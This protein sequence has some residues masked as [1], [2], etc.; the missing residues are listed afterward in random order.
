MGGAWVENP[1]YAL[2]GGSWI[3][4]PLSVPSVSSVV[5]N[6]VGQAPPYLSDL[7]MKTVGGGQESVD[8]AWV[9][10]PPYVLPFACSACFA[11]KQRLSVVRSR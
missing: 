7:Q 4:A 10:N 3:G 1:P 11:L 2:G 8:D 5:K 9:E 6:S